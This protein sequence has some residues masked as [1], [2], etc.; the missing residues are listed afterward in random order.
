MYST[1]IF[2][3]Q[4]LGRNEAIEHFP[5]GRRLAFD[6]AKGRL[7]VVCRKCERWNLTPLE[8]RWEAIEE[9]ER[10]FSATRMR[11]STDHVGLARLK[12]GT[13]LVR[14]G[15]PQRPEMAAWRYGDQF[16]R[17]TRRNVMYGVGATALIF[18]VT[19][20]LPVLG[21]AGLGS[22]GSL[23]MQ[24]GIQWRHRRSVVARVQVTQDDGS[25]AHLSLARLHVA[26]ARL[27]TQ[28]DGRWILDVPHLGGSERLQYTHTGLRHLTD[29]TELTGDEAQRAA[30]QILPHV[31]TMVGRAKTVQD[32]V[33]VM[34]D[35]GSVAATFANAARLNPRAG[36]RL[37][38]GK[39][40]DGSLAALPAPVRLALEMA[41][42]EDAERRALAGDLQV[43]EEAWRSA[44]EIAGIAD[45]LLL[46]VDVADRLARM[47]ERKNGD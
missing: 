13:E 45:D 9:C 19:W 39:V 29:S 16:G 27:A 4:S 8:E 7:W 36:W 6:A 17:R 41:S 12:E 43:L 24:A 30:A 47:K 3:S 37:T 33:R 42:H 1:C 15:E 31:N 23:L 40:M 32:A 10:A 38:S 18:G 25:V 28:R 20:G 11:V 44:E 22:A 34:E 5:V 35:A 2:C 26:R 46:P 21:I 14:I